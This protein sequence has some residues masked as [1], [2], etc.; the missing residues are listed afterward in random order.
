MLLP[1]PP[2]ESVAAAPAITPEPAPS[3]MAASAPPAATA[4]V[5]PAAAAPA[6]SA[7]PPAEDWSRRVLDLMPAIRACLDATPAKPATITKA[8]PMSHG[9]VGVRV[10]DGKGTRSECIVAAGG[11]APGRHQ[12]VD[13]TARPLP[14]E[15]RPVFTPA[16]QVPPAG[17]CWRNEPVTGL[18][19]GESLG[20]LSYITC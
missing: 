17:P 14:G 16:P 7:E 2:A 10:R 12:P 8:W 15:G 13:A 9:M 19:S 20:T 18:G 4:E 5:M 1:P 3:A 6:A 11:G